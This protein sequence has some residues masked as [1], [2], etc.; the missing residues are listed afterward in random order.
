M[1]A[2]KLASVAVE[3]RLVLSRTA[4]DRESASPSESL[5]TFSASLRDLPDGCCLTS[6][7]AIAGAAIAIAAPSTTTHPD[8]PNVIARYSDESAL[9]QTIR[10]LVHRRKLHQ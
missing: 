7:P 6:C 10:Y 3:G 2:S 5:S 1:P 8:F 9:R 4:T